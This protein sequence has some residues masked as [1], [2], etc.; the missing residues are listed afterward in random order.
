MQKTLT[1]KPQLNRRVNRALILDR[2]RVHGEVSRAELAKTTDIKAPTVTAV[3]RDLIHEGFVVETGNGEPKGGRAPRMIA[4]SADRPQTLGFELTETSILAGLCDL[5][6]QPVLRR[7]V[8]FAPASPQDTIARLAELGDELLE[9]GELPGTD[10]TPRWQRLKGVGV[11][12]PG[13]VDS[14]AGVVRWSRP[15]GWKDV[16]FRKLCEAHWG[17]RTDVLND[18]AAGSA[19]AHFLD[20][21]NIKNLVYLVVRFKDATNGVVGLG[22]GIVIHGEPYHGEFGAAGEITSP[23]PH[24]LLDA[25][26]E[27][28]TSF[29]DTTAFADAVRAGSAGATVAM[30][31]VAHDLSLLLVHTINLIEPGRLI[32]EVDVPQL[33][34]PLWERLRAIVSAHELHREPGKTEVVLSNLGDFGGVRGA[35]VPAMMRIFKLPRWS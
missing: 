16:P 29:A 35:V 2:I 33:G 22:A 32:L 5:R 26:T 19:A 8:D 17:V 7:R 20:S 30:D 25:K 27:N 21:P 13:L 1:G 23:I 10:G 34:E 14:T 31:R 4:L 15:L 3:V 12:L 24:P 9:E 18:S 28:G 11:A 6:G